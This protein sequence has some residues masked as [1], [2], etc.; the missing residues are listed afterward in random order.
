MLGVSRST[1]ETWIRVGKYP[2]H[3]L[4]CGKRILYLDEVKSTP[5]VSAMLDTRWDEEM[6]TT[7]T[8]NY[9]S[10]ELFAG[11][12]GL[13]LG[14]EKAGFHHILLNEFDRSACDTLRHNRPDW[15]VI[16]GD[17]HDIDFTPFRDKIDLLSGGFPCQ[18]FSYAGKRLGFEETRGTLF[19]E[20][21]RAVKEIR[22]KVFMG[23]NVRG[24][25]GHDKGRTLQTI[26]DVIAELGYTLINPRVLRALQYDVPQKRERLI[27]IAFPC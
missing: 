27:L 19:F 14:L 7:P 15:N 1:V 18:S 5:E 25:F 2:A 9:T 8:S 12:G 17:V 4:P 13:A 22:P 20:M 26:K 11:C 24:L 21:A 23:E 16:E 6:K 10:A 3:T